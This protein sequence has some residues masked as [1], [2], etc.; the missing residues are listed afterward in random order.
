MNDEAGGVPVTVTFC[1]LCNTAIVFDRMVNGQILDFG[2]TGKLRNSDL[3]MWDRQ[4]ESC[5]QQITG[6]AIVGSMTGAMLEFIPAP[7]VSWAEFRNSFADGHVLSR[8][9]GFDMDYNLPWYFGYDDL[10]NS[11]ALFHGQIDDRLPGME[12]VVGLTIGD[13]T[14]AY[15][16]ALLETVPVINGNV[17]GRDIAVF[18]AGDTL[19]VFA[20]F[21]PEV[22][23]RNRQVGSTGVFESNLD[24]GKLTFRVEHAGSGRRGPVGGKEAGAGAPRKPLLVRL[25]GVQLRDRNQNRGEHRRQRSVH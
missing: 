16:F 19:S 14:V 5:W 17:G 22:P 3:V 15:P 18:Y 2:T 24:G 6:E 1:P 9:T 21:D 13:E 8:D 10:D 7:M 23:W 12:R 20:A 11:P 25:A 4:T